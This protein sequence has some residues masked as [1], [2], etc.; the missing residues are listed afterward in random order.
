M[1]TYR[2]LAISVLALGLGS[3]GGGGSGDGGGILIQ[4]PPVV[5]QS[6][7]G[8]WFVLDNNSQPVQLYISETGNVRSIFHVEAVTDGPTFGV[9]SVDVMGTDSL[10]GALQARGIQPS[11]GAPTPV[12]LGCNLSGTV[13]ERLS[14]TVNIV[15]SDSDGIV[16]DK[17]FTMTQQPGYDGG[18][19][20]SAIAGNYTLA[21]R[22]ASNMLNITADGTLFGM[23]DN[24]AK[25]TLNGVVAIVDVDYSFLDVEW[26]MASCTDSFGIYEGAEMSGFA[27]QSPNPN[28]P[29][30]SYYFL[31]TGMNANG[32]YTI[33]IT[34]EPT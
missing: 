6:P 32:L 31:L 34:F 18:S 3:C 23:Y 16:Y 9:G 29:P 30:E 8:H 27:M 10:N 25:C 33:S 12:D 19:S 21:F 15:C 14:L 7:G 2:C 28:D 13:R 11:A 24:G 17:D 5:V 20:L 4:A 26:T 1:R 22:P